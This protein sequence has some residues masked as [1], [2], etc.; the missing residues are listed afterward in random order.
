VRRIASTIPLFLPV[1]GGMDF[2]SFK[3]VI[4]N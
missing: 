2:L 4:L 1:R 3:V